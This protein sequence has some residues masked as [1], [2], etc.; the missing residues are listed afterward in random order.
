MVLY[1]YLWFQTPRNAHRT[2]RPPVNALQDAKPDTLSMPFPHLSNATRNRPET[3]WQARKRDQLLNHGAS[4][5]D[6]P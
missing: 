4:D 1:L 2:M 6:I 5:G 3:F